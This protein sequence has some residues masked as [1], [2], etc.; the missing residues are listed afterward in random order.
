MYCLLLVVITG[1]YNNYYYIE[2][3]VNG[4]SSSPFRYSSPV[5]Q[6]TDYRQPFNCAPHLLTVLLLSL[7]HQ[8]PLVLHDCLCCFPKTDQN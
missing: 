1:N 6:S 5:V 7:L 2:I 4:R 8:L 3:G